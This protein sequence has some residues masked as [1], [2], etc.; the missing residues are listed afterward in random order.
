MTYILRVRGFVLLT[1][2]HVSRVL[3]M[4]VKD[5]GTVPLFLSLGGPLKTG[6]EHT[7]G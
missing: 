7:A 6:H 1:W 4:V 5:Q 3:I 2:A